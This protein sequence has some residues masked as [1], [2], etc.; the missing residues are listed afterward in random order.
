MATACFNRRPSDDGATV[1][2]KMLELSG[3][4]G[5][6]DVV[7]WLDAGRTTDDL[8]PAVDDSP[9]WTPTLAAE[10]MQARVRA[11]GCKRQRRFRER[12]RAKRAAGGPGAGR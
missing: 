9:A 7:D 12:Q 2:V 4:P 3:L 11:L 6:G 10:E 8:W 5:G 1:T